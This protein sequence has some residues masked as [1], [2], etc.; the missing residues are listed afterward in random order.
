MLGQRPHKDCMLGKRTQIPHNAEE[1]KCDGD[2]NLSIIL[3]GHC[4]KKLII[5]VRT[6]A[7]Q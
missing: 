5:E 2:W 1:Y 6:Y 4:M 7:C 3:S